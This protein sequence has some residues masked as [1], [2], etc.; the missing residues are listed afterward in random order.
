MF[1]NLLC[2]KKMYVTCSLGFVEDST[3]MLLVRSPVVTRTVHANEHPLFYLF[4]IS[5]S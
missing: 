3:L 2:D 5:L 4:L 1:L